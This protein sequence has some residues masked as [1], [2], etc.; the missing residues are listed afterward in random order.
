MKLRLKGDTV[1]L[2]LTKSDIKNLKNHGLVNECTH[3][4][5]TIFNYSLKKKKMTENLSA[6][7]EDNNL[8]IFISEKSV[9][10]LVQTNKV[11]VNEL[12]QCESSADLYL[13]VE[14]DFKCLE[15]ETPES[16]EDMYEH[17]GKVC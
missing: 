14:K 16:Q 11:G 13:L 1:R 17:P 15:D 12:Q 4:G 3:I 9:E 7:F 2:R 10:E 8:I 6:S 5:N